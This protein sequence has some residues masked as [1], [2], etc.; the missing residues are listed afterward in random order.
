M[1]KDIKMAVCETVDASDVVTMEIKVTIRGPEKDVHH[2]SESY[3]DIYE[4]AQHFIRGNTLV[5]EPLA[6]E[7]KAYWP[8]HYLL[9]SLDSRANGTRIKVE[10]TKPKEPKESPAHIKMPQ[11]E[12]IDMRAPLVDKEPKAEV[13]DDWKKRALAVTMDDLR[14]AVKVFLETLGDDAAKVIFRGFLS[15]LDAKNL[16]T[17]DE[18]KYSEM[19]TKL[20]GAV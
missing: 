19:L 3:V 17:L 8:R 13:A 16:S 15:D 20:E 12:V 1:L 4:E 6:E 18:S 5:E 14:K 9:D 11:P 7:T 2:A 10:E